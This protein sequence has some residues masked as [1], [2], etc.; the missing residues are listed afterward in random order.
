M[1]ILFG[2]KTAIHHGWRQV[3]AEMDCLPVFRFLS[4]CSIELVSFGAT[5]EAGY[6]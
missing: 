3:I 2:L 5:L 6:V 4:S 1:A